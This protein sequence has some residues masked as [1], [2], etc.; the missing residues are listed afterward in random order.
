MVK[1]QNMIL[2]ILNLNLSLFNPKHF[3]FD[4]TVNTQLLQAAYQTHPEE[5]PPQEAAP[6]SPWLSP[7]ANCILGSGCL[8]N[9]VMCLP[10]CQSTMSFTLIGSCYTRLEDQK[11]PWMQRVAE[12]D[13]V[14]LLTLWP[15]YNSVIVNQQNRDLSLVISLSELL[16]V[17]TLCNAARVRLRSPTSPFKLKHWPWHVLPSSFSLSPGGHRQ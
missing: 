8:G 3:W 4:L 7:T 11:R 13:L 14:H 1:A 6:L 10:P 17:W 2:G 15:A 9:H 5:G 16:P 12:E